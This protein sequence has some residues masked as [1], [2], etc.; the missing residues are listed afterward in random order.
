MEMLSRKLPPFKIFGAF[1]MDDLRR[2]IYV[3]QPAFVGS[4]TP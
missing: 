1:W 3:E 4:L 2:P